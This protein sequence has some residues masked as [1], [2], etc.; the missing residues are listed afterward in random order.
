MLEVCLCNFLK[1]SAERKSNVL[2]AEAF[3]QH[4]GKIFIVLILC[5]DD[6]SDCIKSSSH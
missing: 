5:G 1:S 4:A 2:R 3:V 6:L